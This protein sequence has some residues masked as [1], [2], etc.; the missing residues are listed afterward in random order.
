MF[1]T[2]FLNESLCGFVCVCCICVCIYSYF[3]PRR[4]QYV[5]MCVVA[6]IFFL[7]LC[8]RRRLELRHLTDPGVSHTSP[9][10]PGALQRCSSIL[11]HLLNPCVA[12]F[13]HTDLFQFIE[14]CRKSWQ[15]ILLQCCFRW[16]NITLHQGL[17]DSNHPWPACTCAIERSFKFSLAVVPN[18]TN[19]SDWDPDHRVGLG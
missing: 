6:S 15:M 2:A 3:C 10:I 12:V 17:I 9:N 19:T 13:L 5:C 8:P 1:A 18:I 14:V 16:H 4:L 7:L 11:K